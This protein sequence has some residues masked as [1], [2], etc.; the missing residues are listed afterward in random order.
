MIDNGP[1]GYGY[2]KNDNMFLDCHFGSNVGM[3]AISYNFLQD[4]YRIA[5]F[6]KAN[7]ILKTSY[8]VFTVT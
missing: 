7:L 2:E 5:K 4:L 3:I 8:I 6:L 1:G